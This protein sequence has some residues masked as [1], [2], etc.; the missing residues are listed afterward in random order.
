MNL[1]QA[2]AQVT[3]S[4]R[5]SGEICWLDAFRVRWALLIYGREV[6]HFVFMKAMEKGMS[7]P[8]DAYGY[9]SWLDFLAILFPLI[10]EFI[11]KLLDIIDEV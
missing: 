8:S 6:R 2:I 11:K 7:A 4:K 9:E 10:L 3:R 5:L 1:N